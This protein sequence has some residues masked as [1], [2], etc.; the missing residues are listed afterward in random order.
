MI[1]ARVAAAWLAGIAAAATLGNGAWPLAFALGALL[2]AWSLLRRDRREAAYALALP[3]VFVLAVAR[4]ETSRPQVA[5]DAISHY[6]DGIAMRVRAVLRDDPDIRATTQRFAADVREVQLRGEWQPASGGVQVTS[7]LYPRFE[8]GDVLEMEGVL[9]SPVSEGA[10]DYGDYLAQRGISSTLAFPR[11]EIA[12]HEDDSIVRATVLRVRRS[13][14]DALTL[15]LPEP[16]SSLAQSVLLGERSALPPDL[17]GDLNAT[18]TSHLVVVS[19][20]NIVLVSAFA[21]L[22]FAWLVGRRRA[23]VLSIAFVLAYAAL[24]GFSAPVTRATIMGILLIVARLSGRPTHGLTSILFAAAVMVGVTPSAS[25]DVSF[26]LSF[27]ATAGIVFLSSPIRAWSVEGT[28]RLV[29][30]DAIPRW[31]DALVFEPLAMTLAAIIATEPL[32]ALN[33]GRISLVAIQANMLIVPAFG[34]ILGASLLAAI[35]GLIPHVHVIASVPAYYA[36]TYWIEIAHRLASLPAAS[37]TIAGFDQK[38]TATAYA[39]IT[40]LA[41]VL[42]R[43]FGRLM[44]PGSTPGRI[45]ARRLAPVAFIA[46]SAVVLVASAGFV[47]W[48]SSVSRLQVTVLEVGQGD[49]ILIEAPGGQDILIDGGP[50]SAVLRGLGEELA[51]HDRSLDAIVLTHPQADHMYGLVDVLDRYDVRRVLAGPGVQSS[52]GFTAFADASSREG[53]RI[54][55]AIAGTSFDLGDGVRLDIIGPDAIEARDPEL[56]NAGAVIRLT[57]RDVS[58]L[59]AADIEKPAEDGLLASGQDLRSTVL[60]VPHHGSRSSSTRAFL[61]AVRPSVSVVSSGKDNQ[62]GHPA[63]DV[64]GRLDDYGPV[65][66]TAESGAVHFE[67]DGARLWISTERD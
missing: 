46:A 36:L 45:S 24:V 52:P 58:F 27:A 38:W 60:K 23:L 3:I 21:T 39:A 40:A 7:G 28:A 35:G 6:N 8:S 42:L 64:V 34:F 1:L 55:T 50:G 17:A 29:R 4:F 67:T 47:L 63:P 20:S 13:L 43:R 14:S 61:D 2:L 41:F 26:Q 54:E 25:R 22:V 66:N 44:R 19:G 32:I 18:N 11:I 53:R 30:R 37:T 59:L 12:G 51:W 10:F 9:D 48:P 57:W 49:A 33:F 15:A 5:A 62:F 65:Y 16:Q 56:N 31:L